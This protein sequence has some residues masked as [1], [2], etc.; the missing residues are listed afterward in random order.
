MFKRTLSA[1]VICLLIIY[2]LYFF[3]SNGGM[4]LLVA[5]ALG[6]QFELLKLFEKIGFK[7]AIHCGLFAGL[8]LMLNAWINKNFHANCLANLFVLSIVILLAESLSKKSLNMI[9]MRFLPTI[10][11]VLYIPFMLSLSILFLKEFS[12]FYGEVSA[13]VMLGWMIIV[14][15]CS[16]IGGMLIGCWIGK[17][18]L[19]PEVSPKKS[20][21]GL[22]GGIAMS[23]IVGCF[24][25][26][27]LRKYFPI[28]LNMCIIALMS[29]ILAI[30]ALIGDL[31]ESAIKRFAN[32][33]DS[34]SIIPGIGGLFDLTDSLI[35]A[36]PIG[37]CLINFFK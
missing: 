26:F 6:T 36:L 37:A 34:G 24:S 12:V 13:I 10:L 27:A 1:F 23:M 16:D 18:K 17:H 5:V 33:K 4:F 25:F 14:S 28:H 7:P 35:F 9:K 3:N 30:V 15:K 8:I 19:I 22:V 11:S 21:E 32:E 2:T 29:S 31:L 20:Y